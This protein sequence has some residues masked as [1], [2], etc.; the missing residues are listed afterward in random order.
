[1]KKLMILTALLS[2]NAFADDLICTN[3]PDSPEEIRAIVIERIEQ[4]ASRNAGIRKFDAY[5]RLYRNESGVTSLNFSNGIDNNFDIQF[6]S[7]ELRYVMENRMPFMSGVMKFKYQVE[8]PFSRDPQIRE[9]L[10]RMTCR[11]GRRY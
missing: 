6:G 1:M 3:R 11:I 10:V 2:L 5:Q 4:V 9:G 8:D 7:M